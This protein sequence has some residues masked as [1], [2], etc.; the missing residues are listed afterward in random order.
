MEKRIKKLISEYPQ[1]VMEAELYNK[2]RASGDEAQTTAQLDAAKRKV[3]F[4]DTLL[5][6]LK[7]M[8]QFVVR[9]RLIEGMTWPQVLEEEE[10][11]YGPDALRSKTTLIRYQANAIQKIIKLVLQYRELT[12]QVFAETRDFFPDENM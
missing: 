12:M 11:R 6:G 3:E 10:K 8:E 4:I 5:N 2:S 9:Q 7:E 1:Y